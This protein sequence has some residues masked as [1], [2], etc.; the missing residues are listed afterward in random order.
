MKMNEK[1]SESLSQMKDLIEDCLNALGSKYAKPEAV[2]LVLATG[3][4]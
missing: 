4:V 2:E 1:M 3:L